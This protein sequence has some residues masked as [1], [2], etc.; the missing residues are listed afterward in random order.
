MDFK[1]AKESMMIIQIIRH[2]TRTGADCFGMRSDTSGRQRRV[3]ERCERHDERS[4]L[5]E[6]LAGDELRPD[7]SAATASGTGAFEED[8]QAGP[9]AS[10]QQSRIRLV[11]IRTCCFG[12]LRCL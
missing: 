7:H 9:D 4:L 1:L 5:L 10:H 2:S 8:G 12:L 6:E 3:V 11:Q